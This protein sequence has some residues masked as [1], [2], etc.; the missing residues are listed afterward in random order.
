MK[1]SFRN[2]SVTGRRHVLGRQRSSFRGG[3]GGEVLPKDAVENDLAFS[4]GPRI[5]SADAVNDEKVWVITESDRSVST[6]LLPDD[7]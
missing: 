4:E 7:Y 1:A 2:S 5:M 3:P 6:L